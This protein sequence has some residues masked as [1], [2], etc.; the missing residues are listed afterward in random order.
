MSRTNTRTIVVMTVATFLAALAST[1]V[2][3]VIKKIPVRNVEVA[4]KHVVVAAGNLPTGSRVT[5]KDVKLAAWPSSNPVNGAFSAPTEELGAAEI[6]KVLNRGLISAIG[7]NEPFTE[8]KLAPIESGAGLPPSIPPGMRAMSV[9][10]DEVVGVAG[11]VVPGTHVDLV[12][13]LRGQGQ[14]EETMSRT[15]VSNVLVLTAGT[16][17]DQ[18]QAKDGQA[19]PSSVVTLAVMPNDAERIALASSE[20]KISLALRNP[21]DVAAT[22]TPGIKITRL[23]KGTTPEAV[24]EVSR[25]RIVAARRPVAAPA[26]APA[27]APVHSIYTVETI[28]AAKRG[29]EVVR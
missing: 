9:K 3:L 7:E 23:M 8:S 24:P 16:R 6:A 22:D 15:V 27:P 25:P 20:G 14:S 4:H 21:L 12:V 19:L 11:F 1:G 18:Q 5:E 26:P 28:R 17:L 13:T 10:V 29:E 2:Y